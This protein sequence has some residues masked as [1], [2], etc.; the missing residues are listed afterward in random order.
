M[1]WYK[2]IDTYLLER[3]PIIWNTN[4]LWLM[5]LGLVLNGIFYTCGYVYMD[6][7]LLKKSYIGGAFFGSSYFGLYIVLCLLALIY[8][9]FRYFTHNPFRHFYKIAKLYFLKNFLA[10]STVLFFWALIPVSFESGMAKKTLRITSESQLRKDLHAFNLAYPFFFV[11]KYKYE[12][13]QRTYPEPFPL[14][15]ISDFVTGKDS[16]DKD[17]LHGIDSTKPFITL[18][19]TDYQFGIVLD[20]NIDECRSFK[21]IDTIVDIEKVYGLS[22]YS[23][24]NFSENFRDEETFMVR[25]S[26]GGMPN[27]NS[28]VDKVGQIKN[29]DL[30]KNTHKWMLEKNE[31]AIQDAIQ[32]VN[33]ICK[34]YDIYTDLRPAKIAHDVFVQDIE[35]KQLI[36]VQRSNNSTFDDI[37]GENINNED[38]SIKD[39]HAKIYHLGLNE[40]GSLVDNFSLLRL[41]GGWLKLYSKD[42]SFLVFISFFLAFALVI[43]K[44]IHF[45]MILIGIVI[46]AILSGLFSI[47][48]IV[49]GIF[50]EN[51]NVK[52]LLLSLIFVAIVLAISYYLQRSKKIS[53]KISGFTYLPFVISS[54]IFIGCLFTAAVQLSIRAVYNKCSG[55]T[56]YHPTYSVQ[57]WQVYIA[58][59][60][61]ISFAF[62]LLKRFHAKPE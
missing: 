43:L 17:I 57:L 22:K 33:D 40:F 58:V 46:S 53:K 2:K 31:R 12:I 4:F 23:A 9:S 1:N 37:E 3:Y 39:S 26:N 54:A 48:G 44:H 20:S 49:T 35:V 29:L 62:Y 18:G 52:M 7:D 25:N 14:D 24:Y 11:D 61:L 16:Q 34:K 10:I 38:T 42:Y 32:K 51:D 27:L 8:F 19:I 28:A 15:E 45:V 50:K 36:E 5:L 59:F 6:L 21:Y 13:E 56:D 47:L 60:T 30:I 55:L 41:H